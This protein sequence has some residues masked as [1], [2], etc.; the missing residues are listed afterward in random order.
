VSGRQVTTRGCE[1]SGTE[2]RARLEVRRAPCDVAAVEAAET[3]SAPA[4]ASATTKVSA[5]TTKVGAAAEMGSTPTAADVA[6]TATTT[7][8]TAPS[9]ATASAR[10]VGFSEADSQGRNR[11]HG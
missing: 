10:T 1:A 9:A 11:G 4:E 7:V 3:C 2:V 8:P 6:A 5:A